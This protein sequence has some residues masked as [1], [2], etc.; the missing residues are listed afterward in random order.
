M[1]GDPGLGKSQLLQ[2]CANIAPRGVFVCGTSA[3][4][5]GLTVA[6]SKDSENFSF[7]A[8]ALLCGGFLYVVEYCFE[9]N[10]EFDQR[11]T[12]AAVLTSLTKW[13]INSRHYLKS[14][15]S[16]PYR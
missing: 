11:T 3:T 15:S 9:I 10:S 7:E 13:A 2:S 14:W 4:S 1:V 6:L 16:R 8:G 5:A 12:A